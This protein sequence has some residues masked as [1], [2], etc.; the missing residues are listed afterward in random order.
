MY[1]TPE[2][3]VHAVKGEVVWFIRHPI[4]R[5]QSCY[6]YFENT[7]G[8]PTRWVEHPKDAE[9]KSPITYEQYV[10]LVLEGA[11]NR[12]WD[13]QVPQVSYAGHFLPTQIYRFEDIQSLWPDLIGGEL[14]HNNPSN[15]TPLNEAYRYD[16]LA[17]LYSEDMEKWQHA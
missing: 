13:A 5:L 2:V 10:D 8:W 17:A 16:E 3:Q 6:N 4:K 11:R 1:A 14:P 15:K 7:V 12:H 9:I